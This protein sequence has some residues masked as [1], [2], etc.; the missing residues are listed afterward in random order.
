MKEI[1]SSWK[2][3][4][5]LVSEGKTRNLSN[6]T[7]IAGC[8]VR[9][10]KSYRNL[11]WVVVHNQGNAG[12]YTYTGPEAMTTRHWQMLKKACADKPKQSKPTPPELPIPA[13]SKPITM[14]EY[15]REA[16][17]AV[18]AAEFE[19]RGW[20]GVIQKEETLQGINYRQSMAIGKKKE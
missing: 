4:H 14:F 20:Y 9:L 11:G 5:A 16:S 13:E 19:R 6:A 7:R 2:K 18:L 10:M 15:L 17:D 12:A 3:F 1:N 8:G